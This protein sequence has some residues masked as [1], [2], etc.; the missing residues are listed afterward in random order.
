MGV[1]Y[2]YEWKRT[3]IQKGGKGQ[4]TNPVPAK[5]AF[6]SHHDSQHKPD[7]RP[8]K[9]PDAALG[10]LYARVQHLGF[11]A[12]KS[13]PWVSTVLAQMLDQTEGKWGAQNMLNTTVNKMTKSQVRNKN[14]QTSQS[15]LELFFK[16]KTEAKSK[17]NPKYYT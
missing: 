11:T 14:V 15:G 4:K 1:Y 9:Y 10:K 7:K 2:K 5:H 3:D 16:K 13:T 12:A 17:I 8:T 6:C